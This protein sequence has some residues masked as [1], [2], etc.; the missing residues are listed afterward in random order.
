MVRDCCAFGLVLLL[1][2]V[3][4][5][6]CTEEADDGSSGT[7]PAERLVN[8]GGHRLHL[9]CTGEGTPVIVLDTGIT[10]TYRTWENVVGAVARNARVLVY[11]RAGYGDSEIGPFPRTARQVASELHRLLGKTEVGAGYLLV[12]H[13]LGASHALVFAAAYPERVAGLV[14]ID[15]PPIEFIM[16]QKFTDLLGMFHQQTSD[17]N[18]LA[19]E[20]LR[21]GQ[22]DQ[23]NFF[24]T[25][26][27]ES[28]MLSTTS[29]E[30]I[31]QI[32][33]LGDIPLIVI[34]STQPNPGFGEVAQE[35]Q[36][37]WIQS[38]RKLASLSTRGKFVGCSLNMVSQFKGFVLVVR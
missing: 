30:Q 35:F 7:G 14:L 9:R 26:A 28:E 21:A 10:E 33:D 6:G 37:F 17:F 5:V 20:H 23:A 25:V 27:S 16:G 38:N 3:T 4:F 11:D 12:G 32:T 15:P 18:R 24:K 34:D 36:E 29:A 13:S 31:A 22:E 1:A 19:Q 2:F 8:V